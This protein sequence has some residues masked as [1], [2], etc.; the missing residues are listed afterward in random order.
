MKELSFYRRNAVALVLDY[1]FFGVG[2]AF[3]SP[4]TTLPAFMDQ[5]TGSALLVG[6]VGAVFQGAWLL[7]QILAANFLANKPFKK[8]YLIWG[9]ALGRPVFF[10]ISLFLVL[11]GYR[12]AMLTAALFLVGMALFMGTDALAALAWF[13][14]LGKSVPASRR[15]RLIGI[16][17]IASALLGLGAAVIVRYLLSN[18]GPGFPNNYAAIFVLAGTSFMISWGALLLLRE[19]PSEVEPK[20]TP[21]R[22]F[23]PQ[24]GRIWRGDRVFARVVSVRLLTG[25][26]ML[27]LPFYVVFSGDQLGLP[28]S[29]I[30]KFVAAQTIGSVVGSFGFGMLSDRK[31]SRRV[32]QIAALL[33]LLAPTLALALQFSPAEAR[34]WLVPF[35]ALVFVTLGVVD[36]SGMLGYYNYVLEI[37]PEKLRPVY[38]GLANTLGGILVIAPVVGG[39]ILEHISYTALFSVTAIGVGVGFL[40]SLGLISATARAAAV[41]RGEVRVTV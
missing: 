15:G 27:A 4:S 30:G 2:L 12:H 11:E 10:L 40:L 19:S 35:F 18:T 9:G 5:L 7:P 24:L 36:S 8:P 6:M 14:I 21:W 34:R 41:E 22:K 25:L 23:L 20:R 16:A 39:W 1:I 31:G 33:A 37:A 3:A 17:Q 32:V 29:A 28:P 13:D 38:I 26:G